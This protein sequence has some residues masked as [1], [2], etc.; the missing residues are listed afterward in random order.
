[1]FLNGTPGDGHFCHIKFISTK[2][3]KQQAHDSFIGYE[4]Y[5]S[6]ISL[7]YEIHFWLFGNIIYRVHWAVVQLRGSVKPHLHWLC[8]ECMIM[9]NQ[10]SSDL[11]LKPPSNPYYNDII[12]QSEAVDIWFFMASYLSALILN[13]V[14]FY[15]GVTTGHLCP[16]TDITFACLRQVAKT[17]ALLE[18]RGSSDNGLF[19]AESHESM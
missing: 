17:C 18:I 3:L 1:M 4:K 9:D 5:C 13:T 10:L 8:F 15:K 12:F 19:W 6:V 7:N 11:R 14:T 16:D 2:V